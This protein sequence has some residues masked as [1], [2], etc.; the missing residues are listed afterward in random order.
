MLFNSLQFLLFFPIVFIVF[1][2]IPSHKLKFRNLFLLA[3]SYLFYGW[4][5][6]RFLGLIILSTILD[7]SAAIGIS[8][9][10][11]PNY[12]KFWLGFSLLAN[13]GMLGFFKYYN[14]FADSLVDALAMVGIAADIERLSLIL[15]VGISFYTFQ[16]MSYSIDVYRR[17]ISAT[18][19]LLAFSAYVAFFPQLVAGPIERAR[20]LLPQFFQPVHLE[21]AQCVDGLRQIVWGFFK[22]VVVAD[23]CALWANQIFEQPESQDGLTLWLGA[24]YFTLQIYGDFSGYSDMAIGLAK[25][26]GFNLMQNFAFPYFSRDMAEFW[27][28]WHIS[29][30][31]WFRDYLYFPLGGSR[32]SFST[33]VRNTFIIFIV[34]GFWHGANWTFVVWGALNALYFLP[35]LLVGQN[36]KNLGV[37]GQHGFPTLREMM[38]VM[39]TFTLA[40]IAWVFFRSENISAA[41]VYVTGMF[42]KPWIW[43]EAIHSFSKLTLIMVAILF[44]VEWFNRKGLHGLQGLDR[45]PAW[46]R[47]L[48]YIFLVGCILLYRG[49]NQQFIYFQF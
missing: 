8:N 34:S 38:G 44:V 11:K 10:E 25:L 35:L 4:W 33:T 15:P 24:F 28:R 36:R 37:I 29:L 40:M 48:T 47:M 7:Y 3:C 6:F 17:E 41:M 5:D 14:F 49:E 16:T 19:D 27:R 1:W 46:L 32:L 21:R 12:R 20:N 9:T 26:L 18:K 30:S 45:L 42:S 23:H 13:L 39:F 22:K 31:T 43:S 2:L